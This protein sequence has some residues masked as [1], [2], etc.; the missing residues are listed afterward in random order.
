MSLTG[1]RDVRVVRDKRMCH[2]DSAQTL[3]SSLHVDAH[4]HTVTAGT[5]TGVWARGLP[6]SCEC[7]TAHGPTALHAR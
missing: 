5:F 1:Q 4:A 6:P 7:E 2:R 3:P